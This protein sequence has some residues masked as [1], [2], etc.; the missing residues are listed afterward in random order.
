MATV[1]TKLIREGSVAKVLAYWAYA[2]VDARGG[3]SEVDVYYGDP[4]KPPY[5]RLR[6]SASCNKDQVGMRLA[7]RS[8]APGGDL[9]G[10]GRAK[11]SEADE[12]LV[13]VFDDPV[14]A[15][16]AFRQLHDTLSAEV[17][18]FNHQPRAVLKIKKTTA[19]GVLLELATLITPEGLLHNSG[20]FFSPIEATSM[21]AYLSNLAVVAQQVV[22]EEGAE[23]D[24][25]L[26]GWRQDSRSYLEILKGMMDEVS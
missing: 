21:G 1:E 7:A 8:H 25:E 10:G 17:K 14:R 12:P 24:L 13:T 22:V 11:C 15:R 5:F 6:L 16:N 3:D 26:A 4:Y 9:P 18:H 23:P 2:T 20:A 19:R